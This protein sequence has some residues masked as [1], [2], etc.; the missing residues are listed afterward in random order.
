[1]IDTAVLEDSAESLYEDKEVYDA[2]YFL[3]DLRTESNK[4]D[5][6][7]KQDINRLIPVIKDLPTI[8][9]KSV[10]SIEIIIN[11]YKDPKDFREHILTVINWV[12]KTYSFGCIYVG[13]CDS[14][15]G[16]PALEAILD[17]AKMIDDHNL[18]EASL[19][20]DVLILRVKAIN[21]EQFLGHDPSREPDAENNVYQS[22]M[23]FI[24]NDMIFDKNTVED[25]RISISYWASTLGLEHTKV[26][27]CVDIH[28]C[29]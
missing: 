17:F 23:I 1:M 18:Y 9:D 5:E 19:M 24:N 20:S 13:I 11:Q 21:N 10:L 25:S 26:C 7:F 4:T 12:R 8:L 15:A 29:I 3:W 28:M 2:Y 14:V 22:E 6:M 16:T 27:I